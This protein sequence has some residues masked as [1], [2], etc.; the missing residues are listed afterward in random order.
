MNRQALRAAY[1]CVLPSRQPHL[2]TRLTDRPRPGSPHLNPVHKRA[3]SQ[4]GSRPL[5]LRSTSDDMQYTYLV[6]V[7]TTVG[8][9]SL[10]AHWPAGIWHLE[11]R[12][13]YR[14]PCG[15]G[16]V[17]SLRLYGVPP[18]V[19]CVGGQPLCSHFS[20]SAQLVNRT[21]TQCFA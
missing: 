3:P 4:P 6:E 15:A 10:R 20:L 7:H 17:S 19:V 8:E 5:L 2:F 14:Y 21:L 13:R 12:A 11:L 16:D 1:G 9:H 18:D